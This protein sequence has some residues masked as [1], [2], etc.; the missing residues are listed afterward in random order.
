MKYDLER[1]LSGQ[2]RCSICNKV[3]NEDI[4]TDLGDYVS[5]SSFTSDPI[6][7][8]FDICIECYEEI[9]EANKLWEYED[10]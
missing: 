3:N 9:E 4:E 2:H 6:N 8:M 5:G 10:E 1:N 7:N